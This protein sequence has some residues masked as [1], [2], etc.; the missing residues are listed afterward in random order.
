M[1][2]T[3]EFI[4]LVGLPGSG[5]SYLAREYQDKGYH[6]HSSDAIRAE[7]YGSEE[8]QGNPQKVFQILHKRIKED[9]R[10]F[11]NCV[12]DAT[13][14][15]YKRRM[16]FLQEIKNIPCRRTCIV[17]ATPYEVCLEQNNNRE[18]KVPGDVIARM[19]RSFDVPGYYEGWDNIIIHY[20]KHF[21]KG[22]YG[23]VEQFITNTMSYNQDNSHHTTTLGQ[24]CKNCAEY[25]ENFYNEHPEQHNDYMIV[26][27]K[28]HDC[29][30][31]FC[32]QFKN[33]KGE[34]SEEA[35]YYN[36]ENV[37]S[38]DSLFYRLSGANDESDVVRLYVANLIHWHMRMYIIENNEKL[39]EKFRNLVGD[40]GFNDLKLLHEADK[41]AH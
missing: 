40:Y 29:G 4:M 38:Y 23:T 16:A 22:A 15:S 17:I 13:N 28:L 8:D 19:Y 24:H 25:I 11:T 41:N 14:I 20:A 6:I 30:K 33:A 12:Y 36:H 21:Y 32:K 34:I 5:K 31:T 18:R 35:H 3:P 10:S 2:T 39:T 27:A 26:A 9:L 7:L 1:N 37:G